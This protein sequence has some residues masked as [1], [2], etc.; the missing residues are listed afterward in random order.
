MADEDLQVEKYQDFLDFDWTDSRWETYLEGLY[1]QPNHR[2]LN[3]FKKK[4]YK[5]NV[6]P[7][8]DDTWDPPSLEP[9]AGANS[10][11][12]STAPTSSSSSSSAPL[13]FPNGAYADG[14]RWQVMRQKA[15]SLVMSIGAFALVF[16]PYQ[17]LLSLVMGFSLELLAKYGLKFKSE[18][19]Q[20]VLLDDVGVMPIMALTLLM[21][22]LH[23]YLR[24]FAI[25]PFFLTAVLSFAQICKNHPT[26]PAW[27]ADFFAPLSNSVAR[28]RIMELRGHSE[29]AVGFALMAGVLSGRAAPF[30]AL[31]FWNFMMMR[32]MMSSWTQSSFRKID[33]TLNPV[34]GK[35]PIIRSGYASLKRKMYGFVD[36]ESRTLDGF[37]DPEWRPYTAPTYTARRQVVR[38]TLSLLPLLQTMRSGGWAASNS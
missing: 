33:N 34:L 2:Q 6:D 35:I 16:P 7:A 28:F 15:V 37:V 13:A 29:V 18:Y 23:P 22:G 9:E 25:T 27:V 24:I 17:A 4:W 21:P 3:K 5:K 32:Y 1:P 36:P 12:G 31:L 38:H 10:S 30:A 11:S 19:L 26:L 14:T 8:L 20:F